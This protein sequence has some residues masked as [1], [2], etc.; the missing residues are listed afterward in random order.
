MAWNAN[1][2]FSENLLEDTK[3][4]QCLDIF[5]EDLALSQCL[6]QT[7]M[8]LG[9]GSVET[10]I[11]FALTQNVTDFLAEIETGETVSNV[12]S[13]T[14]SFRNE[15]E[16]EQKDNLKVLPLKCTNTD[17][18]DS[19]QDCEIRER[20]EQ[21]VPKNTKTSTN[22]AVNAF[23]EWRSVRNSNKLS[24]HVPTLECFE[25]D[26]INKQLGCFIMEVTFCSFFFLFVCQNS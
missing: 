15:N 25:A 8:K 6:D 5:E 24:P 2:S 3:V 17:R 19:L 11:N 22:W 7:E 23:N 1:L 13:E 14:I 26:D 18:Y 21:A 9:I 4:S 12:K 10:G 16:Q 20:T